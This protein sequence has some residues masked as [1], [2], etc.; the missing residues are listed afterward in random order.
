VLTNKIV[1]SRAPCSARS[2]CTAVSLE[3]QSERT[4]RV[5]IYVP[6]EKLQ[7]YVSYGP[8]PKEVINK[9]TAS[10]GRPALSPTGLMGF[11]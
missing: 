5:N 2:T 9:Y 6:E 1:P 4:N 3:L 11:G 10:T 7:Y 8:D